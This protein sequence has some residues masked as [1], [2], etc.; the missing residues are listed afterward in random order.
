MHNYVAPF[1]SHAKLHEFGVE[2]PIS[3]AKLAYFDLFAINSTVWSHILSTIGDAVRPN[4]MIKPEW[5]FGK[6]LDTRT[7]RVLFYVI[8]PIPG[9]AGMFKSWYHTNIRNLCKWKY[10]YDK[11][12]SR[13]AIN[14]T[15]KISCVWKFCILPRRK[16]AHYPWDTA[17]N[18]EICCSHNWHMLR[19][20]VIIFAL[21]FH[22]LL[23]I[24]TSHTSPLKVLIPYD[25]QLVL[26]RNCF[27]DGRLH[28]LILHDELRNQSPPSHPYVI[29][30]SAN[31]QVVQIA[32]VGCPSGSEPLS[33]II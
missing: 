30:C 9:L 3:W 4:M 31:H 14:A 13:R 18:G 28:W 11:W 23:L 29:H 17:A 33:L 1:T 2:K 15:M 32:S 26:C 5:K 10:A 12:V 8:N 20:V 7:R 22:P 27:Q 25:V 21:L 6:W 19:Y 24:T 16:S